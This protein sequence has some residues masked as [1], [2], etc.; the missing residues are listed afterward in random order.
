[1]RD[2]FVEV[3]EDQKQFKHALPLLRI[4]F[5][6]IFFEVFYDGKSIREQPFNVTGRHGVP[7]AAAIECL[8][9]THECLVEKMVEAES[10]V[11][12][13]DRD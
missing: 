7:L 10:L 8:V 4:G 3:R 1:M 6:R 9:G 5:A 12:E 13:S 2:V 11:R